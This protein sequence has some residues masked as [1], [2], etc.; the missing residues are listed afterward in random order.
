ME[1]GFGPGSNLPLYPTPRPL[2]HFTRL[3]PRYLLLT[4][5]HN[6]L[7]STGVPCWRLILFCFVP[8]ILACL[9]TRVLILLG[10]KTT[11]STES[12]SGWNSRRDSSGSCLEI[13]R[14]YSKYPSCSWMRVGMLVVGMLV[15]GFS[16]PP[17]WARSATV[18]LGYRLL[19]S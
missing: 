18:Q 8:W 7:V 5:R 15:A 11:C 14:V 1:V 12:V 9:E 10:T 17:L 6:L 4:H 16:S 19:S 2:V 13:C 3:I